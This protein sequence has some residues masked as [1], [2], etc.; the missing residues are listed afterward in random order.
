MAHAHHHENH[1][2]HHDVHESSGN[3]FLI[4]I[5]LNLVFVVIETLVGFWQNSLALLTDAG[6]NLGDVAALILV[7]IAGRLAKRKPTEKFTYGFGKSTILVALG[8]A[9]LLLVAVGAIG[10]EAI[11][12]I[13]HAEPL[14][15]KSISLVALAGIAVNTITAL[16]FMKDRKKDLNV[17]GAFLHMAA[18][19]L[20]SLGVMVS[21]IVIL[22][23]G[24]FWLD[25][26]ISLVICV[27]IVWSTWGLLRDSLH[28][29]LDSVPRGIDLAGIRSYLLGLKGV[30]GIHDLHVWALSTN[31]TALTA[32]LVVPEGISDEFLE[33]INA[34][35]HEHFHI[36]H[37][38]IQVERSADVNCQ[39]C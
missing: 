14:N 20:V 12:R 27:V 13:S 9:A 37:S 4:G 34:E 36:D 35:L 24:W 28:L 31:A 10:Y 38:T 29:S 7:V 18:D 6:H 30:T 25:P 22:Y 2:H 17:R 16:L 5:A 15:G 39:D 11:G 32:H 19:A 26:V 21:G 8:N 3:A 33:E 1:H 23:T